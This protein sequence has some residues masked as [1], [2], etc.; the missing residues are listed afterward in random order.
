[1]QNCRSPDLAGTHEFATHVRAAV[2]D[3]VGG[4]AFVVRDIR[5]EAGAVPGYDIY[6]E[7]A[8]R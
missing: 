3:D 7:V 2:G 4:G 6:A 8:L 5:Q 1:M